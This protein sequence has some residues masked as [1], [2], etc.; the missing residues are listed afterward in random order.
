MNTKEEAK[1]HIIG[2]IAGL[3]EARL[4][5]WGIGYDDDETA[6]FMRKTMN[7]KIFSLREILDIDQFGDSWFNSAQ[8]L[9][10][11]QDGKKKD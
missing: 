4:A 6:L 3:N 8:E 2:K 10:K 1:A 5:V 11:S 7:D 9:L